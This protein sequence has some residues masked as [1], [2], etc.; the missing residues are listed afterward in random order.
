MR[1][2]TTMKCW[3]DTVGGSPSSV[4]AVEEAVDGVGGADA[5]QVGLEVVNDAVDWLKA[6]GETDQ[7]SRLD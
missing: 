6:G 4:V 3:P 7:P 5:E 1:Q 2:T